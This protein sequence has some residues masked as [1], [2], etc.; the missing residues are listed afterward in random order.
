MDR[1][2]LLSV[3]PCTQCGCASRGGCTQRTDVNRIILVEE[4]TITTLELE[5]WCLV[6]LNRRTGN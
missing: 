5:V 1:F 2:D 6:V 3:Q 4:V